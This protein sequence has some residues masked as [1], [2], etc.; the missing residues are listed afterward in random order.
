MD[1]DLVSQAMSRVISGLLQ[2]RTEKL[3]IFQ[4]L[5]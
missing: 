1:N 5:R 3:L 2:P 4:K